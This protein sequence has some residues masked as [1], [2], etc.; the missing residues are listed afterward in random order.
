MP[1][2]LSSAGA[3]LVVGS[4]VMVLFLGC[5]AAGPVMTTP[6]VQAA[7]ANG[8]PAAPGQGAG[9][10]AAPPVTRK[11]IYTSQIDV[12]V[13]SISSAQERLTKLIESVR[14]QGGYL[15]RQEIIGS[16][17]SHRR[18]SWTVRVPLAQFDGFVTEVEKLGELERNSRD[19]QDVTE[20]YADLEARLKN[21]Q[22]SEARLLSHLEQSAVLKDT[23]EL[24]RELSRVR[25]EIEQIQGQLNVLKNKSDLATVTLTLIERQGYTPPLKPTFVARVSRTF[26][27]SWQSL[28]ACGQ[29]LA[30]FG[31]AISPWLVAAAV[32]AIPAWLFTRRRRVLQ[33]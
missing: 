26:D 17:G 1:Q 19:S 20:A 14:E 2:N 15:S 10:A 21:K 24:E 33:R 11:I 13:E 18:G 5:G 9:E 29:T 6:A 28:V 22:A 7:Q 3:S 25:G 23:L 4:F 12:V 31:V 30:L 27:H 16:V 32:V 8:A